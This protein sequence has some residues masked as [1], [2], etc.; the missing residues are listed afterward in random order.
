MKVKVICIQCAFLVFL[1]LGKKSIKMKT[2]ALLHN[3]GIILAFLSTLLGASITILYK[4]L[5]ANG[6]PAISISLIESCAIVLC[7]A[8]FAKPWRLLRSNKRILYPIFICAVCQAVGNTCFYYGLSYLDPVTFSFLTRNQAVFSVLLGFFF[9]NERHDLSTWLFIVFAVI[10]SVL[11]CYA[12]ISPM[13]FIGVI[14]AMMFCLLFG[15]RNFIL[16]RHPRTP[17]L[18][19]IFYGYLLSII[20]LL[21]L[22]VFSNSY[23]F[24]SVDLN[25]I[26]Q[27]SL[28]GIIASFGTIYTFQLA[29][30]Y[31]AISIISPIRLFSPFM[32]ALFFGWEIGFHYSS[33]KSLGMA[34]MTLAIMSLVYSSRQKYRMQLRLQKVDVFADAS[35]PVTM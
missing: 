33:L 14:F 26:L 11:L 27:I 5:M 29:L 7:L 32:V 28:I 10:G 23:S 34:V 4:P 25:D 30:R 12:D 13:N 1:K 18:V 21:G 16:R 22:A 24:H 35:R 20:L 31:E 3:R 6:M 17:A 8:A 9:L 2:N 15:V 19:N